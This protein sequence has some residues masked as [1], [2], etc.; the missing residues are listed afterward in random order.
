MRD[1][2]ANRV[3]AVIGATLMLAAILFGWLRSR[4]EQAFSVEDVSGAPEARTLGRVVYAQEC[5]L[6]HGND[7]RDRSSLARITDDLY[8]RDDGALVDF[9][10]AGL[11][12][13]ND[14]ELDHPPFDRF[15]D[16]QI[17]AVLEYLLAYGTADETAGGRPPISVDD[18]A[19]RRER[20]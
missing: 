17:A 3:T 10:L 13:T 12:S 4:Q 20:R 2:T 1:A 18:V 19:E 16:A 11:A 8:R 14:Q 7:A 15:S 5:G 9:L 6:C